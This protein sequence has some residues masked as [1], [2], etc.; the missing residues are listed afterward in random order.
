MLLVVT[1]AVGALAV[2]QDARSLAVLGVVGGFM[3]PVLTSDGSGNHVALF[4]YYA[5]L[6]VAV[7]GVAWFKS[8]RV[9]NV[10]GFLFTFAVGSMWGYR[11]YRPEHF[12]TTE[13][14][15]VLFVLI[16]TLIPILFAN[17]QAPNL[18]GFVDGT[19]L[20]GTPIVGFGLQTR[21]VGDT[22]YGLA[23]SAIALAALYVGLATFVHRRRVR[24]LRVIVEALFA[25]S[26]VFLTIAVPLALDARWT[27]VAWALQ[28]AAMIWLGVRQRRKLALASGIALQLAAGAV[29]FTDDYLAFGSIAGGLP[30]LNGA[31]LG[32]ALIA[33]AGGLSGWLVDRQW[34]AAPPPLA[35]RIMAAG[36]LAWATAW[37]LLAGLIELGRHAPGRLEPAVSLLFVAATALAAVLAAP[38]VDWARLNAVG[39]SALP[40]I[41]LGAL[42]ALIA[43]PH[44]LAAYGWIAWPAIFAVHAAVLRM[45]ETQFPRLLPA[46]HAIAYW[47]FALLLAVETAWQV[48]RFADGIWPVAAALAASAALVLATVRASAAPAWPIGVH[49]RTYLLAGAGLVLAVLSFATLSNNLSSPGDPA[50]LPYVPLLNPLELT[51]AFVVLV[52]LG[53][54]RAVRATLAEHGGGEGADAPGVLGREAA[55]AVP[56]LLGLF[57]LTMTIA[58]TVHH[59]AGV[60]FELAALAASTQFQAALSIAWST[61]AL[62]AMLLGA[63]FRKRAIWLAGAALMA[64]VVAKLFLVDLG[65]AGTVGRIV[66]FLGVGI[67]LLV[68]GYFAP[69]PPRPKPEAEGASAEAG[70]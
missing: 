12:A 40:A 29:H 36:F 23:I 47:I 9:L 14:F 48:G 10:L 35:L 61:A 3:A 18:K 32:A 25:L 33:A 63:R 62:T 11:G 38:R 31:F 8:W 69:V 26:L 39:L 57:L 60:P 15:L 30:V 45:R 64:V 46:L 13:P 34:E 53:W 67:L 58:R 49:R 20:F 51:S 50:P 41:V 27:S 44:P 42:L 66:S 70:S 2:L 19:L 68:V 21:L 6:N 28:G 65:N 16:Y 1:I 55:I 24:D 59:W 52:L 43:K 54:W 56:S 37:W 5:V 22:E 17:R 7:V 4:G